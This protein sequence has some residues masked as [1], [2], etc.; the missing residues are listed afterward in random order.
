MFVSVRLET[1]RFRMTES[2][3]TYMKKRKI[4]GLI[5]FCFTFFIYIILFSF[6]RDLIISSLQYFVHIFVKVFYITLI[7]FLFIFLTNLFLKPKSIAKH[8][9]KKSGLKGWIIAIISGIISMGSIYLW[10]PLLTELK[11]KGMRKGLIAAFLYNRAVKIPLLPLMVYYF[12]WLF[13]LSLTLYTII[14]SVFMG[15]IIERTS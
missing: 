5:L 8:L 11:E 13:A 3:N 2:R 14:F 6:K 1:G 10:Y 7:V 4:A 12:G 15:I 9:G